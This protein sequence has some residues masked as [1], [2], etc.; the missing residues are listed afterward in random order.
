MTPIR[1]TIA[2]ALCACLFSASAQESTA[3]KPRVLVFSK[4]A[5]FRHGSIEAGKKAFGE[6]GEKNGMEVTYTEDAAALTPGNL[7][8]C[9]VVVF[10]NTTGDIFNA[11]QEKVFE[12]YIRGGGGYLGIHAANDTEYEWPWYGKLVGTWFMSHPRIQ[13]ASVVVLDRKHPAT[14]MLPARWNHRD[15][16]YDFRFNPKD[17]TV[18]AKVD[19]ST[20]EGWKHEGEHPIIWCH[21]FEGGRA[22]YTGISHTDEA[23]A[24][25]L[26]RKHLL[27]ALRWVGR[28]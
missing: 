4:T 27:G 24:D 15:E 12:D 9:R 20:Y 3:P 21:E 8:A 14:R 2:A 10:L 26:V 1:C 28:L 5:G 13:E 16:W 17:V 7:S 11:S 25:P 6:I 23:F 22:L 18:L 19:P